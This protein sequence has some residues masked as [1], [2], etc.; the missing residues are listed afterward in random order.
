[1]VEVR[2]CVRGTTAAEDE[3]AG[4]AVGGT[5]CWSAVACVIALFACG[6]PR[7]ADLA[8]DDAVCTDPRT[9]PLNCGDC[10]RRCADLP[11]VDGSRV[12]CR[13]GKCQIGHA[14]LAELA[15]CDAREDTGCEADLRD[16]E[17]CGSCDVACS[18]AEP[19]CSADGSGRACSAHCSSSE[20]ECSGTC[21]DV[22]SD[23]AH[24][25]RCDH[26][27][28]GGDCV[29]GQC[30]PV[31]VATGRM[32]P[33]GL[34][35]TADAIYWSEAVTGAMDGR[36]ATCPLPRCTLAPRLVADARGR[37]GVVAVAGGNV[38]FAGC[39]GDTCDDFGRM[40]QC[41]VAGCPAQPQ[42]I[43][44]D[45]SLR[46]TRLTVGPTRVYGIGPFEVVSCVPTDC[47]ATRQTT[48]AT[49]FA[50]GTGGLLDFALDSDALY[51]DGGADLR[52][53]AEPQGCAS[54]AVV[55]GS[56]NIESPFGARGGVLYWFAPGSPGVVQIKR[57]NAASCSPT[58]F[59]SE[60]NGVSELQVD[61][62]GVYWV[63]AS[64]G[65]IRHCPPSGC[66]GA[67]DFVA[68]GL[69][70]PRALTLGA[71]FVYWIEGNDIRRVAKP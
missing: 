46:W 64:K 21:A 31:A 17:T 8:G 68:S 34:A 3:P 6:F 51:V 50:A 36:I 40:Y 1:M 47:L 38:F 65:T 28:G 37:V 18:G 45:P 49:G 26:N 42:I 24:C 53:C 14:C 29:A 71:G 58:L 4:T 61:D 5:L 43:A 19:L 22:V 69:T 62:S 44:S 48:S 54:P 35:V 20:T 70:A 33:A 15:D 7:L 55:T 56:G 52:S 23:G 59:A 63:N 60:S 12:T 66:T 57:C 10:G 67:P 2:R 27:C 9:D 30:Q 32:A 11:G 39:S 13:E 25:G 41:P 16:A